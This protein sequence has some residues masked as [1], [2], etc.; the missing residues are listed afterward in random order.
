[1]ET[2]RRHG[3]E[4]RRGFLAI[5]PL[6]LGIAPFAI[7]FALL[8]RAAGFDLLAT[9]ACSAL[10]F[11]G[12]AQVA[13]VTLAAG[14]AAPVVIVLTA[15][16]LNLRHVLYG[17]SLGARLPARTRPPRPLLALL[18]TDEVYGVTIRA[19]AEGRGS[20]AF[21]FGAG[22]SVYASFNLATLVGALA[23]RL[24]PDP[25][26]LGLDFI[27]P[28]TFLALLLP[29]LRV[30]RDVLVAVVAGG[31]ALVLSRYLPEGV[32]ILIAA[33]VAASMGA[34]LAGRDTADG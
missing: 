3:A 21:L 13:I 27:F 26:A 14:G 4:L 34:A 29:S 12:A 33:V 18:L 23:G 1:V 22:L 8:A 7:T 20:G 6:W 9:Q 19:L 5:V 28:L 24:L 17:L 25:A 16:L 30:R 31:A 2:T 10:I 11:A 15:I 32:T